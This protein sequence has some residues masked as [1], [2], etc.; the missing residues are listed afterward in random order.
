MAVGSSWD[1]DTC[2]KDIELMAEA[3]HSDKGLTIAI[4]ALQGIF[5]NYLIV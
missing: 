4:A 1:C 2:K 3:M 5:R